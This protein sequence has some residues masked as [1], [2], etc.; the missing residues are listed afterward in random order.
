MTHKTAAVCLCAVLLG[1]CSSVNVVKNPPPSDNGI[2]YYRPKPYLLVTPADA[3]GRMVKLEV[4]QLPDYCEEYSIHPKGK[5]PPAVQLKDGWNLVG[6]GGGGGG[7]PEKAEGAPAAPPTDPM[8]LPEYVLQAGNVPIGLYESVFDY[9]GPVKYL[10]GWRYVGFS[11]WGGGALPNG[12]DAQAVA[13]VQKGCPPCASAGSVLQGPLYG[14]VFFNGAM[15]F[16]QI[17]EIAN[18]MTCPSYVKPV[19]EPMAPQ[20]APGGGI[21]PPETPRGG[22]VTNPAETEEE[23]RRRLQP[24]GSPSP[25]AVNPGSSWNSPKPSSLPLDADLRQTSGTTRRTAAKVM[26]TTKS[27]TKTPKAVDPKKL[28]ALEA[29]V[30]KSLDYSRATGVTGSVPSTATP[31]AAGNSLLP[32]LTPAMPLR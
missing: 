19:M 23:R 26:T 6:V 17:D 8:K 14:I 32:A 2:R 15:T 21:A 20:P 5:K 22:G 18:N 4:L 12:T 1:G 3:T 11:P 7:P 30:F 29:E 16:R 9:G 10:K 31:A 28:E 27:S 24:Q 13:N 25:P